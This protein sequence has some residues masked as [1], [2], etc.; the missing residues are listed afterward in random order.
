MHKLTFKNGDQIP[1]L[2]LGTWKSE[3]GEVYTAVRTAIRQGYR[4]IDCAHVYG[5]EREIGE[6]FHDAIKTGDVAREEL[7][8]TSKLWNTHHRAEDVRPALQQTLDDL[9]LDYLD[10]Y[11]IHWPV[12]LRKG[13]SFPFQPDDFIA[14]TEIPLT[15]TWREMVSCREEEM[16]R[17][18]GV[19]NFNITN[20]STL[21]REG[22]A[23]PEMNQVESHP[24]LNQQELIAFCRDHSILVTA[25]SPL[26]SSDRNSR[27]KGEDEPELL[28]DPVLSEIAEEHNCTVAQVILA[29]DVQRGICVIPKS[30]NKSRLQENLEA[31]TINLSDT[32]MKRINQIDRKYRFIDGS[33]WTADGSPYTL[34]FLWG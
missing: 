21:I 9:Q 12:S 20:L 28:K 19:S 6:A 32:A 26:G 2:G 18:V 7:F 31:A 29:W 34:E 24:Y 3:V 13:A 23:V 15:E 4:H 5:N 8:I 30:V 1:R 25:Y 33:I 10:L 14:T 27:M 17:H 11:L 16:T 22:T